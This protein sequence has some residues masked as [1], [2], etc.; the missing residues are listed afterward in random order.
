MDTDQLVEFLSTNWVALLFWSLVALLVFR[1]VRPLVRRLAERVLRR[2]EQQGTDPAELNELRKRLSTVE[3]LVARLLRGLVVVVVTVVILTVLDLISVI[4]A[5]GLVAAG[6]ALAGQAIIMDYLMGILILVEGQYYVGDVIAVQASNGMV[7]GSVE[8]IGLRRTVLRDASGTVH[9]V[10]NGEIR[11]SSNQTRVFANM[12]VEIPIVPEADM[13]RAIEIINRIGAEMFA[14]P[15]WAGRLLEQPAYGAI[16][17]VTDL[18]VTLRAVGKVAAAE[19]WAAAS[20]LRR[21]LLMAFAAEGI[22]VALRV[23]APS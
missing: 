4:V 11:V 17:G 6:L 3:D 14:D 5:L 22:A 19:R 20:E 9:S 1:S 21:R 18:G 10:S 15:D 13:E 8:E 12:T 7:S 16:T 2:R 23:R